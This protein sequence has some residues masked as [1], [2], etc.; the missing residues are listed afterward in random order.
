MCSTCWPPRCL[1]KAKRTQGVGHLRRAI[2]AAPSAKRHAHLGS[3]LAATGDFDGA[4]ASYRA[5]TRTCNRFVEAWSTLAALLKALARYD[6]AEACCVAGLRIDPQHGGLKFTLA[7]VMFE[8]A[9]VEEAIA[10]VRESL[11][12]QPGNSAAHSALLR[13]LSYSDT[14]DPAATF[15]EHQAWAARHALLR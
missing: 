13:M 8:Q 15:R 9:R 10:T 11:A 4:I 12:L 6:D 7:T 1:R 5:A 14:Q 2:E 3:V